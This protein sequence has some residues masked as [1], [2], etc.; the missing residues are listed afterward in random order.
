MAGKHKIMH[1]LS[2][3]A[4]VA[5]GWVESISGLTETSSATQLLTDDP[6]P[7][8][9]HGVVRAAPSLSVYPAIKAWEV[10]I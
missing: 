10:V 1:H 4:V 5:D 3:R 6:E 9:A 8:V 7:P 2:Q